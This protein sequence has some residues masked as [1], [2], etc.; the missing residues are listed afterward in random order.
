MTEGNAW[1]LDKTVKA[2]L[3]QGAGEIER[4]GGFMIASA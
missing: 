2:F 3:C 1:L 4:L